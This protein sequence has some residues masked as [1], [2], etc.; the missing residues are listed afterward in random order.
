M[1]F[2][3]TLSSH[4]PLYGYMRE[5][6][7]PSLV[8][9]VA[10]PHFEVH[11][12]KASNNVYRYTEKKSNLELIGK[13]YWGVGHRS[14]QAAENK[15]NSEWSSLCY[16]RSLG[17]DHGS[18]YVVRPLSINRDINCLLLE[19]FCHGTSF[20]A[21]IHEAVCG[22]H[23]RL[24]RKLTHLASFLAHLHNHTAAN[25]PVFF[26]QEQ[27]YGD[28]IVHAL[29]SKQH[30]SWQ[31]AEALRWQIRRASDNWAMWSDCNVL[32]HGDC[33]PANFLF[34]HHGKVTALDLERMKRSDRAFDLGRVCGEIKHS[35]M[36]ATGGGEASEPF[37]GHF[38]WEYCTHFP[39]RDSAFYAITR[40]VP[41][42]I[43][44]NLLRIARNDWVSDFHRKKLLAHAFMNFT[45][46]H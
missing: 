38:L 24:F 21:I 11:R 30:I 4:D 33:T 41:F 31:D 34:G 32:V 42:Y 2:M 20:S 10:D 19:E 25:E 27:A 45:Y 18:H 23:K 15:M 3:G 29:L 28:G 16:V 12:A 35:F 17:F 44:L 46:G 6:V 43:G 7:L 37:I 14:W 13:F 8:G 1:K 40:R 36:E 5:H 39:D 26:H 9:W 22:N